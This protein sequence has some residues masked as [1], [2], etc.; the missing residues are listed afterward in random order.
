MEN[1][2]C[3]NTFMRILLVEDEYALART[4][5]TG[6]E[7]EKFA[8]DIFSNGIDAYE[9]ARTEEYDV[10]ILDRM[11]QGMDGITVC[12]KLRE[13]KIFTPILMLTARSNPD[14][15]IEGLNSGADDYVAKPFSFG[16]LLAR[17]RSLIRRA[18]TKE[19]ILQIDS[20]I[21]NPTTHVVTR[22]EKEIILTAKEYALLEFFMRH[23]NQIVT[24]EQI[25]NHVWDYSYDSMSNTLDVLIKRLRSKIDK[26]FP[27]EKSLLKTI[28]G[29]GYKIVG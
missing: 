6:L 10:I 4:I 13:Q 19:T 8:V 24:R 18:T 3:Y 22:S 9:Q 1:D 11:I 7:D 5:K 15:K 26:A 25:I 21:V 29:M 27:Q 28:R 12:K 16:E 2:I 23:P 20:L 14:D 17:I